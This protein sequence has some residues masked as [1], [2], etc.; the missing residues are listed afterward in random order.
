M[1]LPLRNAVLARTNGFSGAR[2][3]FRFQRIATSD[4]EQNQSGSPKR[5]EVQFFPALVQW[6]T[7]VLHLMALQII[8]AMQ[9]TS[10]AG[11]ADG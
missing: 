3:V 4:T 7:A 6:V 10:T 5:F 8:E 2:R 9:G 11:C 1:D